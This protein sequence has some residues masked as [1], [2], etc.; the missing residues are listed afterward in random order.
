MLRGEARSRAELD[1]DVESLR[2]RM[3]RAREAAARPID[4]GDPP[5][6]E[7]ELVLA[8]YC[9]SQAL[10][11][12]SAAERYTVVRGADGKLSFC[13]LRVVPQE[14]G[15]RIEVESVQRLVGRELEYFSTKVRS[16][17]HELSVEGFWTANQFRVQRRLDGGHL[18]ITST[19][20]HVVAVDAGS[21]TTALVLG[22]T[23]DGGR[24][25][26]MLFHETLQL[27]VVRWELTIEADGAHFLRTPE[28]VKWMRF[29]ER[30]AVLE[31]SEQRGSSGVRTV[32]T[33]TL[34]KN[35][36]GLP[37]S[38]AK[39][40]VI[41]R[42]QAALKAAAKDAKHEAAPPGDSPGKPPET[43]PGTEGARPAGGG[44]GR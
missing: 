3:A 41:Q 29:D 5:R 44:G 1:L 19:M 34:A 4:V 43:P 16:A 8:G 31:L 25:P 6:V 23:Q 9:E 13:G 17:K 30:G 33:N 22:A 38:E 24:F 26:V 35:R 12:R 21:V 27:E 32:G 20:D 36:P 40:S 42:A 14:D 18:D 28:G 37:F 39:K 2:R 7:G 10:G 15:S 11:V